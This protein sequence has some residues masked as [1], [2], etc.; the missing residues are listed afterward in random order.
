MGSSK[1]RD[2]DK[3]KLDS[4]I[5]LREAAELSGLTTGRLRQLLRAGELWGF[6]PGRNWYT[7]EQAVKEYLA[8]DIRP[9]PKSQSMVDKE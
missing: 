5:P 9:G 6:K 1:N 3:P 4:L 8:R 2:S 7:T